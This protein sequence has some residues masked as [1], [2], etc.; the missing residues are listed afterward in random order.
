MFGN[1]MDEL[2]APGRKHTD[3]EARRLV[4][5]RV[6]VGDSDPGSGPIDLASGQVTV[7][8]AGPAE[9]PDGL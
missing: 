2:F 1:A 7:R 6:D 4:L 9:T 5:S 8:P 3:E